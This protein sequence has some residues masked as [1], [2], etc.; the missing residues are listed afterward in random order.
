MRYYSKISAG[1]VL[2]I[3]VPLTTVS[4]IMGLQGV[5]IGIVITSFTMIFILH[6][7]KTTYY[8]ISDKHLL[9]KSGFFFYQVID[10]MK[11]SE[12]RESNNPIS[13][14][15]AS[16]DRLEIKGKGFSSVLIS[17]KEKTAFIEQIQSIQ[18][19]VIFKPRKKHLI[20]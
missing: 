20:K 7:L 1:L 4:I 18:P 10:I 5:W 6:M 9:I 3:T 11:I 17:P 16:M 13:S 15:A 12:I 14:P 8:E 19:E 2:T